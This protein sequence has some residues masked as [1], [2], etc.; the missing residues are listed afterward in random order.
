MNTGQDLIYSMLYH[1][2]KVVLNTYIHTYIHTY[3]PTYLHTYIHTYIHTY[4]KVLI[5]YFISSHRRCSI[6][7]DILKNT[8]NFTR[9][10]LCWSFFFI[11]LQACNI[12]TKR[13]QQ[14]CFPVKF[15]K[16]KNS[17]FEEHLQ[18]TAADTSKA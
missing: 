8:A 16:F 2:R 9:K 12:I 7:I 5:K 11:K 1:V 17:F 13:L 3:L 6:K 4:N 18:I 14:R 15:A 10:Q